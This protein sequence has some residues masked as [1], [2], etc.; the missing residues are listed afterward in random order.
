M[1][2]LFFIKHQTHLPYSPGDPLHTLNFHHSIAYNTTSYFTKN[3][4]PI[5]SY[6]IL[7]T[8]PTATP[9]FSLLPQSALLQY[10]HLLFP[11]SLK[12]FLAEFVNF[13]IWRRRM[14]TEHN[15]LPEQS[16]LTTSMSQQLSLFLGTLSSLASR[17][18][19]SLASPFPH[20][21]M[22]YQH[23]AWSNSTIGLLIHSLWFIFR[24][25]LT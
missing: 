21:S 7:P 23:N 13:L 17:V 11:T 8:E 4:R 16:Y 15:L 25:S 1:N 19:L 6:D 24:R 12:S 5:C 14:E 18:L 9:E 22:L 20:W 3:K 2:S 10:P